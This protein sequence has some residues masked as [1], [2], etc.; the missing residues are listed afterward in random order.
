LND[1]KISI[2]ED[3][4]AHL[5]GYPRYYKKSNLEE[6]ITNMEN[7]R[8]E[9]KNF[10][11]NIKINM[12]KTKKANKDLIKNIETNK[13]RIKKI[14]NINKN[15]NKKPEN[16][17]NSNENLIKNNEKNIEKIKKANQDRINKIAIN[18]HNIFLVQIL[19][20]KL[21]GDLV[22]KIFQYSCAKYCEKITDNIILI[23]QELTASTVDQKNKKYHEDFTLSAKLRI[24]NEN[25]TNIKKLV[26]LVQINNQDETILE[27]YKYLE[28]KIIQDEA[29][30]KNII[31]NVEEVRIIVDPITQYINYENYKKYN[32]MI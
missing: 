27:S 8:K 22:K 30:I 26:L 25:A 29:K 17:R 16:M 11:K 3:L 15:I 7:I 2:E 6:H 1:E 19:F 31:K 10:I 28:K 18:N 4:L 13:N 14:K 21:P 5:Y 24:S 20:N 32:D 23:H 12:Q 9:D